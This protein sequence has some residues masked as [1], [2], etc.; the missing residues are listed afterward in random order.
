MSAKF[1]RFPGRGRR[2]W[3]AVSP[4]SRGR[5]LPVSLFGRQH[6]KIMRS[7]DNPGRMARSRTS[8]A[9]FS[10]RPAL[11]QVPA[12]QV[13]CLVAGMKKAQVKQRLLLAS[14]QLRSRRWR[15]AEGRY[16]RRLPGCS[17]RSSWH[18]L[19]RVLPLPCALPDCHRVCNVTSTPRFQPCRP[20]QCPRGRCR[21]CPARSG[22]Q[23]PAGVSQRRVSHR[24]LYQFVE[25]AS[26]AALQAN[27]GAS[28]KTSPHDLRRSGRQTSMHCGVLHG[29]KQWVWPDGNPI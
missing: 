26:R 22:R 9:A 24:P 2:Q 17:A 4:K 13:P 28:P 23:R 3:M 15:S 1:P 14:N 25:R 19:R 21:H 27:G 29:R 12:C 10:P 18:R 20:V 8:R 16:R 6:R 5:F 7:L 11:R